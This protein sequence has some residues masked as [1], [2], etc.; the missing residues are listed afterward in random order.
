MSD[1]TRPDNGN[2]NIPEPAET[3]VPA[4]VAPKAASAGAL[5]RAARESQGLHIAA[6]AAAMKVTPRKLEALE[7]DRLHELPDATF[8][9]ALAQTI[10]RTLKI[11][12]KPVLALLPPAGSVTLETASRVQSTPFKQKT[13]RTDQTPAAFWRPLLWG[14][15]LLLAAA[16]AVYLVPA[17]WFSALT[18]AAP[19]GA[20]TSF[21]AAAPAAPAL[22]PPV[23]A[24]SAAVGSM[25][26]ATSASVA[27][28]TSV[29]A[30]SA[31]SQ[32]ATA[33]AAGDV[34]TAA[35]ETVFSAPANGGSAPP[36]VSGALVVNTTDSS[37]IEVRDARG[38]V[39]LSE[40]VLPGRS[41][42]LDGP[43]P[44]QVLV[45]NAAA[46]QMVFMGR[47]VD[48]AQRARENI[49]RFELK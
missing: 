28:A 39:L 19:S 48:L 30:G 35:S 13:E 46:T 17:S 23:P 21:P 49:A 16:A 14:T 33:L 32:P 10:C 31:A 15:L 44:M 26:P 42:G 43:L 4:A 22:L 6:L 1:P 41:V 2:G 24:A 18:G 37:W 8:A 45:G 29:P 36:A 12:P 47:P 9:R 40:T 7:N 5:L 25:P 34:R 3:A 38:Q 27:D 20:S 11:D